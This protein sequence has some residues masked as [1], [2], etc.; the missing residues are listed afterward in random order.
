MALFV[1]QGLDKAGALDLR[2]ATRP[3]HLAWIESL[4]PRVKVGGP[5]LSDDGETPVGSLLVIEAETLAAARAILAEDPYE[6]A[7]LWASTR[8]QPF[9]WLVRQ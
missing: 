5:L 7:G 2:K 6:R 4:H 8:V 9:N 3:A 1:F